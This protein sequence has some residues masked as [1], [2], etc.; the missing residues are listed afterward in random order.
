[1]EQLNSDS[2]FPCQRLVPHLIPDWVEEVVEDVEPTQFGSRKLKFISFLRDEDGGRTD[3][4]TIP[5]R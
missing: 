4:P 1:M 2:G 5:M 3:G